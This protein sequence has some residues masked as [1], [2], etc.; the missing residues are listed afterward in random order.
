MSPIYFIVFLLFVVYIVW[1]WNSTKEFEDQKIRIAYLIV[2]TLFIAMVTLII[3]LVSKIGVNYP[4]KEMVGQV[5]KI[6]LLVFTPINGFVVL[7]QFSSVFQQIRS[8]MV[9]KEKM[10]KKIKTLLIVFTIL[11]IIEC[12][13]FKNV[14]YGIIKIINS[15]S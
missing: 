12:I 2:G 6:V 9:S 13:Y 3:F 14:Q 1:T 10:D 8:G 5:Q 4:K 7:T 15:K 11:I